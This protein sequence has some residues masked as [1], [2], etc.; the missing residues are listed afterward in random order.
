MI[1]DIR[2]CNLQSHFAVAAGG[3]VSFL[4]KTEYVN[5]SHRTNEC[6]NVTNT[7]RT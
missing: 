7:F 2:K 4:K 3:F 5:A 1:Q 6:E